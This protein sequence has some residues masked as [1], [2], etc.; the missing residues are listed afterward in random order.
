MLSAASSTTQ[1]GL[2]SVPVAIV[3]QMFANKYWPGEDPLGK[4]LRLFNEKTPGPWLTVVGVVSNIIQNDYH[5]AKSRSFGLLA[6]PARARR[7]ACGFSR[8][9]SVPPGSLAN[10]FRREVQAL[11]SDLPVYGP[12]VLTERLERFW[13]SRFYGALFLIFAAIALLLASIGLYTVVAHSVSQRT[14][15]IGI[16]M[17]VG[18]TARD[19]LKLVFVQ[20]MLPLGNRPGHRAGRVVGRQ[21]RAE[22]RCWFRFRPRT[23]LHLPS[24]PPRLIFSAALGCLDSRTPRDARRSCR[25]LAQRVIFTNPAS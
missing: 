18:A 4:R 21:S 22:V 3:N 14:Q 19:I 11:D 1:M 6:V 17:A 16:R 15:E 7:R 23:Q 8:E 9:L 10:A 25:G 13:D 2:P 20:G 5:P 12:F 24:R